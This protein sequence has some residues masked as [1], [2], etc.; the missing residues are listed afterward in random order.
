M[1]RNRNSIAL[2]MSAEAAVDVEQKGIVTVYYKETCPYCKK[3]LALLEGDYKLNVSRVNVLEG[4]DSEKKIKQMKTFSG[5]NTVPQ[6]FFNSLH[7]GGND[8][9]QKLHKDG[10]LSEMVAT[11]RAEPAGMMKDSW[12]HPWY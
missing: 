2:D 1:I 9:V 6:I 10:K 11:V 7:I 8:D 4:D 3:A 5:R 12:Y